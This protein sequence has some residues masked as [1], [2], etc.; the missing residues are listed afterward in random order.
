MKADDERFMVALQQK[1]SLDVGFFGFQILAVLFLILE[2]TTK[3]NFKILTGISLILSLLCLYF[4]SI[5]IRGT[6]K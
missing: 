6:N 2:T 5:K 4:S 3:V 1:V